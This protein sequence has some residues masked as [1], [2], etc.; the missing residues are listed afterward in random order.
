[1]TLS[2][3]SSMVAGGG[4]SGS[5][6]ASSTAGGW[7]RLTGPRLAILS[8][9][10]RGSSGVDQGDLEPPGYMSPGGNVPV[11]M[12]LKFQQSLPVSG[13]CFF[14]SLTECWTLPVCYRD[15]YAQCLLCR[16]VESPQ[17]S[18]WM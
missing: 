15:R 17:R 2:M 10:R 5:R 3:W 8:G 13:R 7:P 16:R 12:Q 1:M 4:A 9:G 6:L 14:R 18:S 11:N